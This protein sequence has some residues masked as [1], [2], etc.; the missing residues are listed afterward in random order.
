MAKPSR[1]DS[2]Q[3]CVIYIPH[4]FHL[5][6]QVLELAI[7]TSLREEWAADSGRSSSDKWN[8]FKREIKRET[9]THSAKKVDK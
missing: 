8:D 3:G 5:V 4:I 9:K 2:G 6:S 7:T 1:A